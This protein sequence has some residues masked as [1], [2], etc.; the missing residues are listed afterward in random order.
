M[1]TSVRLQNFK[2]H[3]DTTVELGRF[4]VLVGPNGSGKTSVLQALQRTLALQ[5]TAVQS[6]F[7]GPYDPADIVS[8]RDRDASIIV[9]ISGPRFEINV[10]FRREPDRVPEKWAAT[11]LWSIDGRVEKSENAWNRYI[12]LVEAAVSS[13]IIGTAALYHFDADR[14][15]SAAHSASERPSVAADGSN[16][17]EVLAAMKLDQDEIFERIQDALRRVVPNVERIRVRRAVVVDEFTGNNVMGHKIYLDFRGAPSVPAHAASEGT[18]ITLALLTVLHSPNRPRLVLLDDIDQSLHP[19]AQIEL[20]RQIKRLLDE[21]PDLQIVATTHSPYILDE[22]DPKDVHVFALKND[23]T[24]AHKRLSD[25]QEA[26][27]GVLTSGQIWS[28]DP[29]EEWVAS[30][31]KA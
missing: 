18:L 14:I 2:A 9:D 16:T 10:E 30:E 8:Q 5:Y 25:H 19:R 23:G 15:A 22:L 3:R 24:V 13:S 27:S 1:I 21:M 20:V 11:L 28:L 6:V 29:E 12:D 31:E 26:A 7:Y 4:T 17:A